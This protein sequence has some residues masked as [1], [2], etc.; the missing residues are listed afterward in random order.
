MIN[1]DFY[2]IKYLSRYAEIDYIDY[3]KSLF[4]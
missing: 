1:F 3:L 4:L 2:K